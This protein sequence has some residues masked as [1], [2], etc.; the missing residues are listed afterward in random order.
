MSDHQ[1]PVEQSDDGSAQ[2]SAAA[3]PAAGLPV[4]PSEHQKL[5]EVRSPLGV[6]GLSMIT[7]GIYGFVWYFKV[8]R[9]LREYDPTIEVQP[10]VAVLAL[11]L[12]GALCGIPPLVSFVNTGGRIAQAQQKAGVADRSSGLVGLL[13]YFLFGYGIAYYQSHLNKIWEAHGKTSVDDDLS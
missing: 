6:W 10:G 13:L 12:G 1:Q 11:S 7:F 5:G 2:P 4:A 8:N 3:A 9:E